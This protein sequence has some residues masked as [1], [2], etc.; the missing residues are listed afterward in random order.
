MLRCLSAGG[1]QNATDEL[2]PAPVSGAA[3]AHRLQFQTMDAG[4]AIRARAMA[5]RSILVHAHGRGHLVRNSPS[6]LIPQQSDQF[7]WRN[8]PWLNRQKHYR[9][10]HCAHRADTPLQA[11]P[12]SPLQQGCYAIRVGLRC[13]RQSTARHRPVAISSAPE[14]QST[15]HLRPSGLLRASASLRASRKRMRR[16]S[17]F[18]RSISS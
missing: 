7:R 8:A 14:P 13:C 10:S 2:A 6:R 4:T 1:D 11:E 16:T 5:T 9:I 12:I 15:A 17:E 18:V 3:V